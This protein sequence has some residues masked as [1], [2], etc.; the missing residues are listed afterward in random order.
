MAPTDL[1][2]EGVE[3]ML[4]GM[5]FVFAF[6]ILLIFTIRLMSWLIVRFIPELAPVNATSQRKTMDSPAPPVDSETLTAIKLA[7]QQHRARR[8]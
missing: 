2:L 4:F 7:I 8:R 1:L 6:L 3:L 5:G